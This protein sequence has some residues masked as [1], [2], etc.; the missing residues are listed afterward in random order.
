[1]RQ[2]L[3]LNSF[4]MLF[5]S[6]HGAERLVAFPGAECYGRF[7]TG[8]RGGDVYHVTN[9][10]DSGEGSLR[11][12]I[13]TKKSDVPRTVV[14]DV[15]GTIKLKKELRIEG[16]KDLTLAGQTASRGGITLRDHGINF[17]QCSNII[18]R[19][20]RFRLGDEIETSEDV[21]GFG[22]ETGMC[23]EWEAAHGLNPHDAEDR[24]A[25]HKSGYPHLERYL[26][27]LVE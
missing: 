23:D 13:K 4:I 22:P 12:A 15:G 1:M 18:V 26:N 16:V 24:N 6:L 10:E 14:F 25:T 20:M 5:T 17:R 19:F 9:I 2:T 8:G 11:D 7:A 3:A 21:I 27:L